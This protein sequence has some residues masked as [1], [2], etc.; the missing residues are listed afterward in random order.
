M[1]RRQESIKAQDYEYAAI[2]IKNKMADAQFI[3]QND[4]M[5]FDLHTAASIQLEKA[6][7]IDLLNKWCQTHLDQD[8]MKQLKNAIRA[9]R[10]RASKGK[11]GTKKVDLSTE[12]WLTLKTIGEAEGLTLSEVIEKHLA[13]R[14]LKHYQG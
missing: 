7:D 5:D 9:A 12:A 6:I 10:H 3:E 8:R 2:W 1:A 14:F 13:S 11:F 4:Q